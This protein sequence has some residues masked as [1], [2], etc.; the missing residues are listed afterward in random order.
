MARIPPGLPYLAKVIPRVAKPFAVVFIALLL[1]RNFTD[2]AIP[3]YIATAAYAL[4]IPAVLLFRLL[5]EDLSIW[6]GAARVG[7]VFPPIWRDDFTPGS[8][9]TV[10][11]MAKR[12]RTNAPYPGMRP[13]SD[14]LRC[15][16]RSYNDPF[17]GDM[18]TEHIKTLGPCF[19]TR[20]LF[21]YRVSYEP[22]ACEH[23]FN[24]GLCR[25]LL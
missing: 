12:F 11:K 3:N 18:L 25:S 20:T 23:M 24:P 13:C 9:Y 16:R 21:T 1:I 19:S 17:A 14:S 22:A 7:G 15:R 2:I 5:R 10:L 6:R 4:A 8:I